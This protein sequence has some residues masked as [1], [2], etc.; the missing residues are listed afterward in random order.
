MIASAL[1]HP[2]RVIS[3]C[4]RNELASAGKPCLRSQLVMLP[5][6]PAAHGMSLCL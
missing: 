6:L 2:A 1:E 4:A 5:A 3:A